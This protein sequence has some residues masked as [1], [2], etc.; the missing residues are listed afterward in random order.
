MNNFININKIVSDISNNF[1]KRFINK[2]GLI[3]RTYPISNRSII[4]NFDDIIPFLEYFGKKNII[5]SQLD[6]LENISYEKEL[7]MGG[8]I[9]SYKIDE[10]LGGLNHIFKSLNS[11]KAK[12]LLENAIYKTKKYFIYNNNI[13]DIYDIQN[14]KKSRFYSSWSAGLLE[15]FL[16]IDTKNFGRNE[17][18]KLVESILK[19][20][21]NDRFYK[22]YNIFPFRSSTNKIYYCLEYLNN[23][24]NHLCGEFPSRITER[25]SRLKKYLLDNE[26]IFKYKILSNR[27]LNSGHWSQLMKSNTTPVFTMIELYK[28]T[29]N[30]YW[31]LQVNLWIE[32]AIEKFIDKEFIPYTYWYTSNK[33][34]IPSLVSGFIF[35]DVLCDAFM[36]VK[37][38]RKWIDI[39]VKISQKCLSWSWENNLIP[40]GPHTNFNHIDGQIDFSISIRKLSEIIGDNKL[41]NHSFTIVEEV[42]NS[43]NSEEGFYTHIYKGGGVKY[44]GENTIDPKYNGLLLKGLVHL[45]EKNKNIYDSE[46][47]IDLFKDR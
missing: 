6:L 25:D 45:E 43:H 21:I 38:E 19:N 37:K 39:A 22:K 24:F 1:E 33:K 29:K 11:I 30:E 26:I 23:Q 2:R 40:M 31:R 16:E 18:I 34:R 5:F 27:F 8:V 32:S 47:L 42:L 4:D 36:F 14:K 41:R 7:S 12:N 44:I 46:K 15:T 35:I 28:L 20:W 3:S 9:Y 17:N 13:S 10:Y